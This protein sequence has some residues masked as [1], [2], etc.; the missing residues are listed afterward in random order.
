MMKNLL[1]H[2]IRR[3]ISRIMTNFSGWRTSR[4]IVVFESDDWGSIRMP[5]RQVYKKLLDKG[6][7]LDRSPYCRF[8]T[9]ASEEDLEALFHILMKFKDYKDNHPV[10]TANTIVANPDFEKIR[11]SQFKE[12]FYEPFTKTL[13]RYPTREKSFEVWKQGME[14]GVFHPQFHGREHLNVRTWLEYLKNKLSP[15]RNAFDNNFWGFD[16]EKKSKINIQAAFDAQ[17]KDELK[18]HYAIV[19]EGLSLFRDIFKYNSKSFI[20]PNYVWDS[21]LNKKLSQNGVKFLQ[22]MKMQKLPIYGRNSREMIRHYIGEKNKLGQIHLIRNCIFEPSLYSGSRVEVENCI[23][24]INNAFLWGR[25][26]IITSHRINYIGS[27]VEQNRTQ[28]LKL[29]KYLLESILA[30]WPKVE[31]ISSDSLGNLISSELNIG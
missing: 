5:S 21:L 19:D 16:F 1:S 28:N 17:C 3:P 24:D 15:Y 8:D 11:Q 31:F 4:K 2:K 18:D 12:Y 26:A 6:I 9:L 23:K 13:E 14:A 27:I 22:G 10:I 20:A 7:N 30:R 29:L 25:P